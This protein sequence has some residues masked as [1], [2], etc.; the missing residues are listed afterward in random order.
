MIA[1]APRVRCYY[2]QLG[3]GRFLVRLSDRPQV[4]EGAPGEK[5]D[6]LVN[7]VLRGHRTELLSGSLPLQVDETIRGG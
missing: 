4:H 2:R 5:L 6:T 3:D 7:R 1:R